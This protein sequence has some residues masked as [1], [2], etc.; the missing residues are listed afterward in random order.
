V[1]IGGDGHQE[2]YQCLQDQ[3]ELRLAE[4]ISH[5]KTIWWRPFEGRWYRSH[6]CRGPWNNAEHERFLPPSSVY[7]LD[8]GIHAMV[9]RASIMRKLKGTRKDGN[10]IATRNGTG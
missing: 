8:S 10:M 2:T 3:S 4:K 7:Q 9:S 6:S 5:D 1:I